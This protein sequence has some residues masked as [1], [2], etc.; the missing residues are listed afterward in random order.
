ML[1]GSMDIRRLEITGVVIINIKTY[2]STGG[3]SIKITMYWKFIR[4]CGGILDMTEEPSFPGEGGIVSFL[5]EQESTS[6]PEVG[7]PDRLKSTRGKGGMPLTH[8]SRVFL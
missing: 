3:L 8:W 6:H 1:T 5:L 2:E 4:G 7:K